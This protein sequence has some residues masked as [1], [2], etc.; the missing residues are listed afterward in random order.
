LLRF[1]ALGAG[2]LLAPKARGA[3]R[4]PLLSGVRL[5]TQRPYLGDDGSLATLGIAP[6]RDSAQLQFVLQRRA[7]VTLE[8]L[9][10]GQG[11]AAEQLATDAAQQTV[12][13]RTVS[14]GAGTHTLDWVPDTTLKPRTYLLRLRVE[15]QSGVLAAQRTVAR[16]LGIDAGFRSLGAIPGEN[17]LLNVRT[18]AE[19]LTLQLFRCGPENEPTNSNDVMNGVPVTDPIALGWSRNADRPGTVRLRVGDWQS[20][21][22]AARLEADDGRIGFAPLVIR[23]VAPQHRV[24]VV[25]PTSTWQAYNFYDAD[26]DG[27]GDTWYARWKTVSL[28]PTRPQAN[29]GVPYRFRSY[30]L[31]FLRWL[32]TTGRGVDFYADEDVERF[33]SPAALRAAYDLVVFPGHT[34]YVTTALFDLITGYRDAGGNL[35]FL[36]ANNFFRR[37]DRFEGS[38]VL[39]DEWRSLG[40]P[41][42]A[43]CGVQY[44]AS[45]RGQRHGAF[46]AE[47]VDAAPWAFEGTGL[48]QGDQFGVYGIEIDARSWSSPS[49]VQVLARIPDLFGLGRSAEMTYYEHESGARV[50]SAGALNFGGQMLLWPE[51]TRLVD[52]VWA[53][54]GGPPGERSGRQPV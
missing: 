53:R 12:G 54:L 24:A 43:L 4:R 23:P 41:E 35:M 45:D 34:E 20:G 14:L 3:L 21:V 2:A 28:D 51:S 38:L 18:D 17:V 19:R 22:Y 25:V 42:A 50:F 29:R 31:Q 47:G 26:G 49:G 11:A 40:R 1:A 39:V 10:T 48:A 7:R 16:V 44:L 52:N 36:S 32:A 9:V 30:D 8:T 27:W 5:S 15:D 6:G 33:P 46:V 37:V 13:S